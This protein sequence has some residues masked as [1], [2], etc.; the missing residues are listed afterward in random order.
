MTLAAPLTETHRPSG[1]PPSAHSLCTLPLGSCVQH[2]SLR[3]L[4]GPRGNRDAGRGV[5]LAALGDHSRPRPHRVPRPALCPDPVLPPSA[6]CGG[7][8]SPLCPENSGAGRATGL[9]LCPRRHPEEGEAAPGEGGLR[10][11]RE[12]GAGPHRLHHRHRVHLHLPHPAAAQ[13][14]GP[15]GKDGAMGRLPAFACPGTD[16]PWRGA[17][18]Q[19]PFGSTAGQGAQLT[20]P[21]NLTLGNPRS[22]RT[23]HCRGG[24]CS[25]P[26]SQ[27]PTRA[28]VPSS[29]HVCALPFGSSPSPPGRW[30]W[31]WQGQLL[32]RAVR[33]P[34]PVA[35]ALRAGQGGLCLH[36]VVCACPVGAG[37]TVSPPLRQPLG[38]DRTL[39]LASALASPLRQPRAQLV[40][41]EGVSFTPTPGPTPRRVCGAVGA[42]EL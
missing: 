8:P 20:W 42:V 17:G 19:R 12:R 3:R 4:P 5:T 16:H 27:T 18:S 13:A 39:R 11:E 37:D 41:K 7:D 29:P 10:P 33:A 21:H 24:S 32:S 26:R 35:R 40:R 23:R 1:C 14:H 22:D 31:L 15:C 30:H 2:P 28:R 6:P 25:G 38:P 9:G 36:R 34:S